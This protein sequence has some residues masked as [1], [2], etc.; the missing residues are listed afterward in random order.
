MKIRSVR[1]EELDDSRS[2]S[3]EPSSSPNPSSAE[4]RFLVQLKQSYDIDGTAD[5]S[6][7]HD[8]KNTYTV[9][10]DPP[11]GGDEGIEEYEFR[12]FAGPKAGAP[13]GADHTAA[14]R[15]ALRSPTPTHR[16]PGFVVPRRPEGY[17]FTG[18][19]SQE[20]SERFRLAAVSGEDIVKGLQRK[21]V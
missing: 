4:A 15:I 16:D 12:L 2:P 18:P 9:T 5:M 14:Q 13:A 21:W 11:G 20:D 8:E 6:G 10:A 7:G 17:Y 3:L 1:R 19:L